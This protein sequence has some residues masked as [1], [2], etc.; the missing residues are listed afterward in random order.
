[1]TRLSKHWAITLSHLKPTAGDNPPPGLAHSVPLTN[2]TA[3]KVS[4][5]LQL[6]SLISNL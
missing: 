6:P 4:D 1:M 2:R 5:T 3:V